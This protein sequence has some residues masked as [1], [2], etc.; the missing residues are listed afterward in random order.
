M[1]KDATFLRTV[2]ETIAVGAVGFFLDE[3]LLGC[4]LKHAGSRKDLV[5][6]KLDENPRGPY[7]FYFFPFIALLQS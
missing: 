4:G 5:L 6:G 2:N 1:N 3:N 7:K